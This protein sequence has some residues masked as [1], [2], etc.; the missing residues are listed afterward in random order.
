MLRKMLKD[1]RLLVP[2]RW[3]MVVSC[4]WVLSEN[5]RILLQ[6]AHAFEGEKTDEI[7]VRGSKQGRD[8]ISNIRYEPKVGARQEAS[9]NVFIGYGY[10][11]DIPSVAPIL[12]C[13]VVAITRVSRLSDVVYG[14][15]EFS[16]S[17]CTS[18]SAQLYLDVFRKYSDSFLKGTRPKCTA[19]FEGTTA[20]VQILGNIV[21][22][23]HA[24]QTTGLDVF[25]K[26]AA[27]CAK[28]TRPRS[29]RGPG[30]YSHSI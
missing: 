22:R 25:W 18:Q 4:T 28:N 24:K 8:Q 1:G 16:S 21:D 7:R 2:C 30:T 20:H 27:L 10:T 14:S 23:F 11:R 17:I 6:S 9:G 29:N 15:H 13:R 12:I 3:V 26:Y 19:A 5:I